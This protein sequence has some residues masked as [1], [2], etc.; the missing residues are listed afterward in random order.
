VK[1]DL[2]FVIDGDKS[3]DYPIIGHVPR[4]GEKVFADGTDPQFP[5]GSYDV[6]FVTSMV[7]LRG[8]LTLVVVDL[9]T[10]KRL[11]SGG[12]GERDV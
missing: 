10:V 5:R 9:V 8:G 4:V 1:G 3:V 7:T 6:E 11:L 12:D 2:R